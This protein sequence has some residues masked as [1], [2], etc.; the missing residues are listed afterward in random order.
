MDYSLTKEQLKAIKSV[1][2]A[3]IKAHKIGVSFWDDYGTLTAFNANKINIPV[4]DE[5]LKHE[6]DRMMIEEIKVPNFFAG[7]ADDT[8]YITRK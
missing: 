4:P 5:K 7:N 3:M 1:K 8:L 2:E 6:L